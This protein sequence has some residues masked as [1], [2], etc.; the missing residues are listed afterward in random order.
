MHHPDF[1][2]DAF[3]LSI[4][5]FIQT[6]ACFAGLTAFVLIALLVGVFRA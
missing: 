4:I 3:F 6:V 1:L 5:L 2:G